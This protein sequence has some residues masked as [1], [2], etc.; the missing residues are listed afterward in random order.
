VLSL[1]VGVAV[2]PAGTLVYVANL[3]SSI[4]SVIDTGL[5]AVVGDV[6]VGNGPAGVAIHPSGEPGYAANSLDGTVTV[7]D[8]AGGGT[9][10][11]IPVGSQPTGVAVAADGSRV[12][13]TNHGSGSV[14]VID[15]AT[16]AV[17]E[18]ITVGPLP[19]GIA[20]GRRVW[21]VNG[22]ATVSVIDPATDAVV[23]T[24]SVGNGAPAGTTYHGLALRP[25]GRVLYVANP[26]VGTLSAVD[27]TA[28]AL[29][30]T[31]TVGGQPLAFGPFA[32]PCAAAADCDDANPC[33]DDTCNSAT[34]HCAHAANTD[35][36]DDDDACTEEDACS[37]GACAG[38]PT[39]SC[40]DGNACTEDT[41][42]PA[43]GL[44]SHGAPPSCDDDNPCTIDS[45][46]PAAGCVHA[47]RT[48][49]CD[50][51]DPCTDGDACADGVCVGG[52]APSCDDSD[53]CTDDTCSPPAGCLHTNNTAAC[54]D[55]NACTVDDVCASGDCV[56]GPAEDCDDDNPCTDDACNPATGCVHAP[57]SGSCSDDNA[58]TVGDVCQFGVCVPGP[59]LDCNDENA[60]TEDICDAA[61][62]CLHANT[63]LPCTDGNTCTTGDVCNGGTCVGGNTTAGCSACQA[64]AT[65]PADG[66]VFVGTTSGTGTL[67][68]SCAAS[69]ISPER[70]YRWTPATS[71]TALISTCG[72]VTTYDTVLHIRSGGCASGVETACNDDTIGCGVNDGNVNA[73]RHGSSITLAVNAG[74]T[75]DIIVDGYNGAAGTFNLT[76]LAPAVCGDSVRQGLEQCDGADVAGCPSGACTSLCRCVAPPGGLPDLTPGVSNVSVTFGATVAAGDVAEGCAEATSGVDLLRFSVASRNVG[77]ADLILGATECPSPCSA[78]P[79]EVCGNPEFVCSPSAGH[80][81]AHY[82][83]FARYE[84]LDEA[85]QAFIVGHKQGFCLQDQGCPTPVYSCEFQGISAGCQD[86]YNATLGCQY[87]DVTGV[88]S[89]SYTLR[90]T[91]DPFN[92]LPELDE[93]NNVVTLPVVI[94]AR[95]G[96]TTTSTSTTSSSTT[97]TTETTSTSTTST[98]ESTTSSTTSSTST[99]VPST[100]TT[101]S[102]VPTTTSTSSPVPTTTSTSSSTTT[103]TSTTE[104][105]TTAPSTS[106]TAAPT[107]TTSTSSST[108][109]VPA[110]S[111]TT[112][113]LPPCLPADCDDDDACTDDRCTAE[114]CQHDA[115]VGFAALSC[116][117]EGSLAEAP[118]T[119]VPARV[120]RRVDRAV[121]LLADAESVSPRKSE[122]LVRRAARVLVRAAAAASRAARRDDITRECADALRGTLLARAARLDASR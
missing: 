47:N 55:G 24:V 84:L 22:N 111:P 48:G 17:V 117:F 118:C 62:G 27:T 92:R 68:G 86:V 42:T 37:A 91:L 80:N 41:C 100:T 28:N 39:T 20:A 99:T 30:G 16:N 50:D 95:P 31:V 116:L 36:C 90:V 14:S 46:N 81:H 106:S 6:P 45:C 19:S 96:P 77:T 32:G 85:G 23:A 52:A 9:L 78:H 25:D 98:T 57:V 66:G 18:T 70:V 1:P 38:Q 121:T 119:S 26:A 56:G 15:A 34:G 114:G 44:C 40:D 53:P 94:P 120:Q 71:G 60:C 33:T 72:N 82:S 12:Y 21:V 93:L 2:N 64:V 3:S 88:P 73:G 105:S 10:D 29:L 61:Q 11:T 58:C 65:I 76:V 59:A 97:S 101:S 87:L 4:L 83:G 35:P 51:G 115:R 103:S 74:Q 102:P 113:T 104:T 63:S 89:G 75:Y 122:R 67:A 43:T 5:N 112:T 7:F 107:S 110:P 69:D 54:D 108:S 49:S 109:T 79:L 8:P 13:V